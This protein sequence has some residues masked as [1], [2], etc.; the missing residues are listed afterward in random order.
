[1]TEELKF[2]SY[3]ADKDFSFPLYDGFIFVFG[4][5]GCGKTTL[6]RCFPFNSSKVFNSD[7]INKNIYII[8]DDN[9]PKISPNNRQNFSR[10]FIGEDAVKTATEITKLAQLKKDAD[11]RFEK[12]VQNVQ[13]LLAKKG[14]DTKIP[15]VPPSFYSFETGSGF[16]S[17]DAAQAKYFIIS[18]FE[19]TIT[20]EEEFDQ[21]SKQ[22]KEEM[23]LKSI[24]QKINTDSY[25][26]S[27][28]F[29]GKAYFDEQRASEFNECVLNIEEDE[30][31]FAECKSIE[32]YKQWLEQG[33]GLE[34]DK[35]LCLFCGSDK[36]QDA[37][38]KWSYLLKSKH[39]AVKKLLLKELGSNLLSLEKITKE[40]DEIKSL[41]PFIFQTCTL[42][43]SAL[44]DVQQQ[45]N[46]NQPIQWSSIEIKTDKAIQE[47]AKAAL[48][49]S[50]YLINKNYLP[51]FYLSLL[52]SFLKDSIAKKNSELDKA[53]L[54]YSGKAKDLIN[55]C[56]KLLGTDKKISLKTAKLGGKHT[57]SWESLDN[58]LPF[59]YCDG[60]RRK[61]A[62]AMFFANIII[63]DKHFDSIVLDDPVDSLD[64]LTYYHLR[65]LLVEKRIRDKCNRLIILTH[66]IHYL[67]IQV[68][69]LLQNE[70]L[71]SSTF[72]FELRPHNFEEI[73]LPFFQMDDIALFKHMLIGLSE[74]SNL[75]L[76]PWFVNRIGRL[77]INL[78]VSMLGFSPK[79]NIA[80]NLLILGDT[81]KEMYEL[82]E[83]M[84]GFSRRPDITSHDVANSLECLNSLLT[85]LGFPPLVDE[86]TILFVKRQTKRLDKNQP[87]I[88]FCEEI[89]K[90]GI[91]EEAKGNSLKSYLEHPRY[92]ITESLLT[93]SASDSEQ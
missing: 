57:I 45:V 2:H 72:I 83:R 27:I 5:N 24:F 68:S 28:L 62:L 93:I 43:Y 92:Q 69:N 70:S 60:E 82:T 46:A 66:N 44:K 9:G 19:T 74:N 52:S 31:P 76:L 20:G 29:D 8:D 12:V 23:L 10:L 75:A 84:V 88:N 13:L 14:L 56:L 21:I 36:G 6:S 91:D 55:E 37:K 59:Q 78:R 81:K 18:H 47:T 48:S 90:Y 3:S 67:Y 34:E 49:A 58:L 61:L 50:N 39:L 73:P 51:F 33:V 40:T 85:K 16:Q 79:D 89:I 15:D 71:A 54:E 42:I 26:K 87:P 25:L 41:V 38:N 63:S 22:M 7:F 64:V 80:P 11:D 65:E 4:G 77:F 1:L 30:K 35:S 53:L 86:K 32:A 17:I